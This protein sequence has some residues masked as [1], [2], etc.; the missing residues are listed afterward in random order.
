VWKTATRPL[1]M[2][3]FSKVLPECLNKQGKISVIEMWVH[4]RNNPLFLSPLPDLIRCR[5][6]K[7]DA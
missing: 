1:Y 5:G 7:N 4:N 6:Q 2:R 3:N